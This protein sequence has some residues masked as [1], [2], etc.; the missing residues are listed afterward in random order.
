MAKHRRNPV[1]DFQP[2]SNRQRLLPMGTPSHH[3][4]TMPLRQFAQTSDNIEN[5]RFEKFGSRAHL[6]HRGGIHD[7]LSSRAPVHVRRRF[8]TR[9]PAD[10]L[11]QGDD[12]KPGANRSLCQGSDID[13]GGFYSRD[14]LCRSGRNNPDPGLC[15]SKRDF[16]FDQ[17]AD[18]SFVGEQRRN[19]VIGE[20]QAKNC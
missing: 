8:R 20:K 1:G 12:R 9:L 18:V 14:P 10:L 16:D 6:Q 13:V 2:E 4:S 7:V 11:H 15:A 3:G 17:R 19:L 5:R